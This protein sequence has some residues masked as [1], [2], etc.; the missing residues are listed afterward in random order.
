MSK[1]LLV[2]IPAL[3]LVMGCNTNK[4]E[5][6]LKS[7]ESGVTE[8]SNGSSSSSSEGG[9]SSESDS[10]SSGEESSS[11]EESSGESSSGGSSSSEEQSK[12]AT[13]TLKVSNSVITAGVSLSDSK[14]EEAFTNIMGDIMDSFEVAN[15]FWQSANED[16]SMTTLCIGTGKKAGDLAITFKYKIEKIEFLLQPQFSYVGNQDYYKISKNA[17]IDVN[18]Q[19]LAITSTVDQ[20]DNPPEEQTKTVTFAEATKN[21]EISN[22]GA[23]QRM[24]INE[25]KLTYLA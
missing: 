22:D 23:T 21:V 7:E 16:D 6:S 12:V 1:R 18:G 8:S 5:S 15:C 4:A 10:A 25:M 17:K 19:E 13:V 3:F 20:L 9:S 14:G 24:F 2:L 11:E